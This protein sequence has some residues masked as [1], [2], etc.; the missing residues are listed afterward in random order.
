[1]KKLLH[2]FPAGLFILI[3]FGCIENVEFSKDL[4]NAGPPS[5]NG[6][7]KLVGKTA[8]S[9][10]V[11]AEID[12]VYGMV[13][14]ER[15][16][17][18]SEFQNPTTDNGVKQ[19]D[20][21]VGLGVYNL[22]INGL[23]SNTT[24]YIR[25]YAINAKG[26]GYGEE[27]VVLTNDGLGVVVTTK[28]NDI[29][30]KIANTGGEIMQTGEGEITKRGIYYSTNKDFSTKS[31]VLSTDETDVFTCQL[32]G[33]TP[34]QMYY[35]Q[36]FVTNTYGTFYGN[37]DSLFTKDG[38]SHIGEI[39][40]QVTGYTDITLV[41][42]VDDG[43]D[44]TVVIIERGFCWS[45]SHNPTI[46]NDTVRCGAG[47]GVFG[48]TITGLT[49]QQQYFARAYSIS[50]C[51]NDTST[52][53]GDEIEF[54]TK[55]DVPTVRTENVLSAEIQNG[56]AIVRG[57]VVD[58]GMT[59]ILAAG[60][61]WSVTNSTPSLSDNYLTLSIGPSGFFSGS[62]T[63]LSGGKTYYIRA[64]ATN[65]NGTS[66]GEVKSFTTAPVFETL[67]VY[68][69]ASVL[70]NS[71]SY[72]SINDR[73]YLLCGDLGPNYTDEFWQFSLGDNKWTQ[74]Q[75][76]KG[77]AVKWATSVGFGAYVYVLGGFTEA[78]E[79]LPDLY[80][81]N[82]TNN[83]WEGP[84]AAYPDATWGKPDS[85][86][87]AAGYAISN[88]LYFVGGMSADTVKNEVWNYSVSSQLWQKMSDFPVKQ[89]GGVAVVVNNVAYVGMGK[90]DTDTCNGN[91]WTSSD[92]GVTWTLQTTCTIFT[93]SILAGV[94]SGQRIYLVD[95][96]YYILEYDT[97]A[98]TWT[99][100]SRLP[101]GY[102]SIHCM[103]EYNG[104][105]YFGLGSANSLI[106]YD[107]SWDN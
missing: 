57:T 101:S 7:A 86:Y 58:Q 14:T 81:Y 103:Y 61:C 31:Y 72:F 22:K 80:R 39:N 27:L 19:I 40:I 54:Y 71:A 99:K 93:G 92:G 2:I 43:G 46:A 52:V 67:P 76:F 59:P 42:S 37:V 78:G 88:S 45:T 24:Y 49:A 102:R 84:I 55:T 16:V 4:I 82:S 69:G 75:A 105:I 11:S 34:S 70:P 60:I 23:N 17:C 97:V 12:S 9:I 32:V 5:F 1:M 50:V 8:A 77:G 56:N 13:I 91:F 53:Y 62:I 95:E 44:E 35:V 90:D 48:G 85:V 20:S 15:G 21:N 64:Y 100:K 107:P 18:Y 104:L 63:G 36:A 41:S 83:L 26:I 73:L 74:R 6:G 68:T 30:A 3:V 10:D 66:Y 38:L 89:Y 87:L 47:V 94:A 96:D 51:G 65:S 28:P 29:H 33:L 106:Y 98:D 79:G 25:P